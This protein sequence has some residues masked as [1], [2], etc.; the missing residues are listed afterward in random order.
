MSDSAGSEGI[1]QNASGNGVGQ[2]DRGCGASGVVQ[3]KLAVERF[4]A[5]VAEGELDWPGGQRDGGDAGQFA[6]RLAFRS[7]RGAGL[8]QSAAEFEAG[9]SSVDVAARVDALDDLLAQVAAF[10]EVQRAGLCGLLRQVA[11]GFG[12]ANVDTVAR[13]AGC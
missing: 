3:R 1:Q 13:R 10:G 12:V 7:E 4:A 2:R 5:D 11:G 9:K 8:G 6:H